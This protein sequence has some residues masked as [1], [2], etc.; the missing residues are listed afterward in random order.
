[1]EYHHFNH[2]VM[3]LSS[4][5]HNIF[6]NLSS[7]QYSEAMNILKHSIISTDLALHFKVRGQFFEMIRTQNHSWTAS[8]NK[9]LLR[10]ILMTA[11]D[12]AASTK[13]WRIQQKIAELVTSEFFD[14]GDMERNELK[15]EPTSMFDRRRKD[16]LPEMQLGFIDGVCI[17]LYESL[18]HVSTKFRPMLDGVRANR[19]KW[20]DLNE[21]RKRR[22]KSSYLNSKQG[23]V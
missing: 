14:Q 21:Q 4:Q 18:T 23:S 2:A 8:H 5:G 10:S 15:I 17:P 9:E 7:E 6:G 11:S 13:P 19:Q 3:I 1:M 16:E 22:K 12:V 20:Y